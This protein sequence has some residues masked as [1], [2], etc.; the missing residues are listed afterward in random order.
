M[1]VRGLAEAT[2][3]THKLTRQGGKKLLT[4][5]LP[6]LESMAGVG[7]DIGTSE[8]RLDLPGRADRLLI[9]LPSEVAGEKDVPCAKF[10]RRRRELTLAWWAPAE[11][12]AEEAAK[13]KEMEEQRREEAK[14]E[15]AARD[16]RIKEKQKQREEER[17]A[18]GGDDADDAEVDARFVQAFDQSIRRPAHGALH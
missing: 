7:V 17:R 6:S 3:P 11:A 16:E 5:E 4:I 12:L 13:K 15:R 18:A 8:I 1:T 2:C 10:S 14:K 9:P